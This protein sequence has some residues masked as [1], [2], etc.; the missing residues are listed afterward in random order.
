MR[1]PTCLSYPQFLRLSHARHVGPVVFGMTLERL[2]IRIPCILVVHALLLVGWS[3]VHLERL[4]L[5][6]KA[7]LVVL[8]RR[9]ICSCSRTR[10]TGSRFGILTQ[11]RHEQGKEKP[12]RRSVEARQSMGCCRVERATAQALNT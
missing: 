2:V 8:E 4:A 9:H 11:A 1:A 10:R 7:R 6:D 3:D 5:V 12:R